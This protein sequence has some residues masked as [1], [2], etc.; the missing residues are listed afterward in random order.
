MA[1]ESM[2]MTPERGMDGRLLT[3]RGVEM[4]EGIFSE[5]E[6]EVEMG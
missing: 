1:G 3:P 2:D 4:G 5:A 6:E